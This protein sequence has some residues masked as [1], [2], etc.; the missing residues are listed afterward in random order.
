MS[1][2]AV[3]RRFGSL[4]RSD[5]MEDY[6]LRYAPRAFRRWTEYMVASAA[7]GGIA[8]LA[9]YAI[10]G[11]IAVTHGFSSAVW[12]IV[13]A[14]VVIFVT[15]IP[16]AYYAARYSIDMDLLT[17]GAG[18]GYLGST[19]TSLIYATFTFIFFS[20]E[21]SIMA[22][23]LQRAVGVPLPIGYLLVAL[24]V[25]PFVVYGMTL[26]SKL[27]AW[28]QPLWLV[29][30]VAPVA[31]VL[32]TAP[33]SLGA[34]THFGGRAANGAAF[35]VLAFGLGAG[36]ALSLI[37]QIGEQVDYL[38]FMPPLT[39]D[40]RIRWWS[41]VIAAGPGWVILGMLK[42]LIGAF[43]AF[44][45]A[46]KVGL[47]KAVEPIEQ[48]LGG[49]ALFLPSGIALAAATVFVIVSQVK[50]NVTNAYSG[51]LSWSNFFSRMLHWHPGR[52][53]WIFFNVGIALILMEA[54]VFGFLNTVLGFYSNVAIAWIG[55]VVADL[56][57]NKPI[58][59]LSPPYIEFK[60]AHLH[61]INPVGFGAMVVGSALSVAA[62]FGAFGPTLAAFSPFLALGVAF[63]LSPIIAILTKGR[64]Y[65]A[66]RDELAEQVASG[67]LAPE[68][69]LRCRSCD[70]A[71]EVPDMALC[72]WHRGTVCSLCCTL[73]SNCHDAC[74]QPTP[75][76]GSGL[77]IGVSHVELTGTRMGSA[78]G[79]TAAATAREG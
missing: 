64:Y 68:A 25:I 29:L 70:D 4:V 6:S 76:R 31:A 27:Q 52:V 9:D 39:P 41:A 47:V 74:K 59:K 40:N 5:V 62:Y 43:L 72:P 67:A 14:A 63:V 79:S 75:G 23:A 32:A 12:A 11:S 65:I 8:Y 36:V 7:L 38:R 13:A 71:Y 22:Q 24:V 10:G 45:V 2:A 51:S 66:R 49:F 3:P 53:V 21:G 26:L 35:D 46:S 33:D 16:I 28:T 69:T 78:S 50:I 58:L 73:E 44:Y 56:V 34:W 57:I 18:F 19:I 60:R 48:N 61:T 1:Q 17:R 37:A 77:P 54:G 20:L 55:A 15:G 42:Q 30:M